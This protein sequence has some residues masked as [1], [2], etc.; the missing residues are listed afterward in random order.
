MWQSP[1]L[2]T[3]ICPFPWMSRPSHL[4]LWINGYFVNWPRAP[5]T[6][7]QIPW[8]KMTAVFNGRRNP[9]FE[10]FH[11]SLPEVVQSGDCGHCWAVAVRAGRPHSPAE[12]LTLMEG[13]WRN[14]PISP[15]PPSGGM[16]QW[17]GGGTGL[18]IHLP[19]PTREEFKH[20]DQM[21]LD[22]RRNHMNAETK[23]T[24]VT[25]ADSKPGDHG[26]R[27]SLE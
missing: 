25:S 7:I 12:G 15:H 10:V 9:R 13:I 27:G 14:P 4:G 2:P 26:G 22:C 3:S 16:S 24:S 20:G 8:H 5:K 23:G 6:R 1:P 21:G 11:Q 17:V 18:H 19:T